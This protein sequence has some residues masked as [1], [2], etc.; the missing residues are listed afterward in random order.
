MILVALVS[1]LASLAEQ[2]FLA[3]MVQHLL[4]IMVAVPL[5]LLGAPTLL[6]V[7]GLP[8]ALRSALLR[9]FT[10]PGA[11]NPLLALLANPVLAL[12]VYVVLLTLWHLPTLYDAALES[13]P[14]HVLE[15]LTFLAIALLFWSQVIDPY[16][17]HS[18]LRYPLRIVLLFVATAHNTVLGGIL[19]FA[20]PT[21][22][23]HY[24]K[25]AARPF[26]ISAIADQQS[27]GAIMWVPGGMV[28]LVAISF[29]FAAWLNSE[30]TPDLES[31]PLPNHVRT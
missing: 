11:L 31:R 27:G 8:R 20:E 22:Y 10:R 6:L 24:A 5:V 2:L 21:L 16:P 9:P 23:A 1:P 18:P 25:L 4:L 13:E 3:H 17:F 19:S 29:V 26:G 14:V 30:D 7:R 12:A 15:H 28:H